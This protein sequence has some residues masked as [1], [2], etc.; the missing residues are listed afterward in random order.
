MNKWLSW[1][2]EVTTC[3]GKRKII[4]RSIDLTNYSSEGDNDLA[5]FSFEGKEFKIIETSVKNQPSFDKDIDV[6]D[7]NIAP[8]S[9]TG[10]TEAYAGD[11]IILVAEGGKIVTAGSKYVWTEGSVNGKVIAGAETSTLKIKAANNTK[12]YFVYITGNKTDYAST[13]VKILTISRKADRINGPAFVCNNTTKK[14]SLEVIGGGLG[15]TPSGG[16]AEWVWRI[17]SETGP[18]IERGQRISIDQ[19]VTP[20]TYFVAP[21]GVN[22]V[23]SISHQIEVVAPTDFSKA[24]IITSMTKI[25]Q[26]QNVNLELQGANLNASSKINWYETNGDHFKKIISNSLSFSFTPQKTSTYGVYVTDQCVTT[27]ELQT[28]ITVVENSILPDEITLDT[29]SKGRVVKLSINTTKAKLNNNSNWI[30][31]ISNEVTKY[32]DSNKPVGA[33]ILNSGSTNINFNAIKAKTIAVKA[34]GE[35][36][37]NEQVTLSVPRKLDKYFFFTIGASSN[38]MGNLATKVITVGSHRVYLRTRQSLNATAIGDYKTN[39]FVTD[40]KSITNFPANSGNYYSFNGEKV[41]VRSSYTLG[42]FLNQND[43][44]VYLGGGIGSQSYYNG[45]DISSYQ[46][47]TSPTKSWAQNVNYNNSGAELEAGVSVKLKPFYMM[48]GASYLMGSAPSK[49]YISVDLN[50][51]FAF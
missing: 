13:E 39:S 33:Q 42:F 47:G 3:D 9:I 31:Y 22:E 35:C 29:S 34:F 45:V 14:I 11:D 5:D 12:K 18:I 20:T 1:K 2:F 51:G 26:G 25:C 4:T 8:T 50:V 6:V 19:P 43:V 24:T 36:E 7:P 44:K 10:P 23:G 49:G 46:N 17:N 16:K 37:S 48:A 28:I 30:W 21:E 40:G 15:E 38:E 27:P 41:N 32:D